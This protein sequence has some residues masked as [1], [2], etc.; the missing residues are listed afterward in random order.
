[1]TSEDIMFHRA[2]GIDISKSDA[3]VCIRITPSAGRAKTETRVFGS[4]IAQISLLRTWLIESRVEC[5]VMESTSMY[6]PPFWDGLADAGFEVVLANATMVKALKGRKSD[7]SDAAWLAKLASLGMTPPSFVPS[8]QIRDLRLVTRA[9]EKLV[10][11]CTGVTASLEK[12]LEDTGFKLSTASSKLLNVSGRRILDAICAGV[13]DPN[14]LAK[15]SMLRKVKGEALVESLDARIRPVHV[16]L[17]QSYLTQIDLFVTE[18]AHFDAL[19]NTYVDPFAEEVELLCTMPGIEHTLAC[20]IIGE[21]GVDMT[22]FPTSA[23]LAAWAGVAPGMNQSAGRSKPVKARK[24]NKHLKRALSQAARSAVKTKDTF[25]NAGFQRVRVSRGEAKAYPGEI[26]RPTQ[27][28]AVALE[29]VVSSSPF[30]RFP[31]TDHCSVAGTVGRGARQRGLF[32]G[33]TA[34]RR[35]SP[36][37]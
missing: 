4:T 26:G 21:I 16:E 31:V 29:A 20:A 22:N 37:P 10:N 17:I 11:R 1:M 34:N 33:V 35:A 6:W 5:V 36:S 24:G 28:S 3:K 13:R 9:R 18:I 32:G 19:I 30:P 7:L 27:G 15:L 12:L 8:R 14:E 23:K 25:P 2:A